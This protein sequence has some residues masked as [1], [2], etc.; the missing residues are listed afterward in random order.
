MNHTNDQCR[1]VSQNGRVV[2]VRGD[3]ADIQI[4]QTSA[5]ASCR[6]KGICAAGDTSAK[7]VNV[8]NDGT[9]LPG[10]SVRLDM[11]ERYGWIG[12]LFAFVFPLT[13]VVSTL[14]GFRSLFGSEE[15]AALAGIAL[16]APYYGLLYLTRN[17]FIKTIRFEAHP[18]NVEPARVDTVH[19]E[20][21][22]ADTAHDTDIPSM[23]PISLQPYTLQPQKEGIQ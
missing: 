8:P 14:F 19:A 6:I 11:R 20:A 21:Q 13:I 16:L 9:L 23:T 22:G 15:I 5:C 3:V 1:V 7:T 10:M 17:Y 18:T 12:V 2:S 4:V